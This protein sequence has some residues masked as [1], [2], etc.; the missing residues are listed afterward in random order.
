MTTEKMRVSASSVIRSVP[1]MSATPASGRDESESISCAVAKAFKPA[2]CTIRE[3]MGRFDLLI[4][5]AFLAAVVGWVA[6]LFAAPPLTKAGTAL[7][8]A[9]AV[10]VYVSASAICHQRPER[11]FDVLGVQMPVCARC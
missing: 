5:R 7:A 8:N 4:R 10:A 9:I 2:E 1:E 6:M 11:S 3:R